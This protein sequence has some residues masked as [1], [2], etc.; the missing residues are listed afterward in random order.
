MNVE[1][2]SLLLF[3]IKFKQV[4]LPSVVIYLK[5]EIIDH[6]IYFVLGL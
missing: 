5:F 4:G 3:M 1:P 2:A 6:F